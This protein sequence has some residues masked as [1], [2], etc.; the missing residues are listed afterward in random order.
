MKNGDKIWIHL[1][2]ISNTGKVYLDLPPQEVEVIEVNISTPN[3]PYRIKF[4]TGK[5]GY[6]HRYADNGYFNTADECIANRNK[7]ILRELD[8]HKKQW[9]YC[10]KNLEK[11]IIK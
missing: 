1:L 2:R 9:E 3:L 10:K 8:K 6:W 11:R 5:E 7:I 4:K